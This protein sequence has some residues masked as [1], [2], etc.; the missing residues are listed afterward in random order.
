M[1]LGRAGGW[2]LGVTGYWQ[3]VTG[4][5]PITTL[6]SPPHRPTTPPPHCKTYKT[7]N[8]ANLLAGRALSVQKHDEVFT[9]WLSVF[10]TQA[11]FPWSTHWL[12]S[13]WKQHKWAANFALKLFYLWYVFGKK[14]VDT[15]GCGIWQA[16]LT[17]VDDG[18]NAV[19]AMPEAGG[20]QL[21][22]GRHGKYIS[23]HKANIFQ[24]T[25]KRH[26]CLLYIHNSH[27]SHF[28]IENQHT[29]CGSLRGDTSVM[30]IMSVNDSTPSFCRRNKGKTREEWRE[31]IW[32]DYTNSNRGMVDII[33]RP[34][35]LTT[36]QSEQLPPV[37]AK[38]KYN[39]LEVF[40]R[41]SVRH[42]AL[43]SLFSICTSV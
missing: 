3:S 33:S 42:C 43:H 17:L 18:V 31:L 27:P 40:P 24:E 8:L 11:L 4:P 10:F 9:I 41:R 7:Q 20:W 35:G 16:L 28:Y 15:L 38:K 1:W 32:V 29:M 2:W 34:G 5:R 37:H 6:S 25:Q 30:M 26:F 14:K 23:G 12:Q 19:Q 39:S 21:K 13:K 36:A 22:W